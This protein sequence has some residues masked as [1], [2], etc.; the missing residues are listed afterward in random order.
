MWEMWENEPLVWKCE[1][2]KV[3]KDKDVDANMLFLKGLISHDLPKI[4]PYEKH[5][6]NNMGT[7][8][9]RRRFMGHKRYDVEQGRY[10]PK[11]LDKV[12]SDQ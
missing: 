5:M 7:G 12:T 9:S 4:S 3:N 10:F 2:G 6:L 1:G 11:N 8:I